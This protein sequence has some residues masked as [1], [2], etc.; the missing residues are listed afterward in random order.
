[1]VYY[2]FQFPTNGKA[3]VNKHHGKIGR[4]YKLVSIPYE[5]EGT[6][7]LYATVRSKSTCVRV[8]IPYERE[9]TCKPTNSTPTPPQ[10]QVSIPYEREGTCKL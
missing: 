2:K 7:K 3:R 10:Q 6:C 5:R 1:M 4:G 9:G 8:S